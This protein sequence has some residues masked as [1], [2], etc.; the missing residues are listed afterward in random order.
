MLNHTF[1]APTSH[2]SRLLTQAF[3]VMSVILVTF[4]F[5]SH[6]KVKLHGHLEY[7]FRCVG[8]KQVLSKHS[9]DKSHQFTFASTFL[10][11]F[12]S[13]FVFLTL[14]NS[15]PKAFKDGTPLY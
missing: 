6:F 1:Q 9:I 4:I 3:F 12:L 10:D 14:P 13:L 2:P 15:I 7:I 5:F 8:A 11:V